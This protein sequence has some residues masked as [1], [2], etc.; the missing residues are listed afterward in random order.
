MSGSDKGF[1]DSN[2]Y[3]SI[4]G[5]WK[6]YRKHRIGLIGLF[7]M[8]LFFGMAIFAPALATH[9]PTPLVKVAP[10][11][12][13]PSWFSMFDP[14]GVV[15]GDYLDDPFIEEE[16]FMAVN[17]T[18][19]EFS[20][21]HQPIDDLNNHSYVN[22]T[23]THTAGTQLDFA[24][25]DPDEIMPDYNDFVYF[26]QIVTWPWNNKPS[27]VNMS[28]SYATELTG[29]FANT[30]LSGILMF[31][32]YVWI[33]DS[34]GQWTRL[35]ESRDLL[36]EDVVKEKPV[37]LNYFSINDIFDGMISLNGTSQEDPSDDITI[38]VGLA[39]RFT[40]E[41]HAGIFPWQEFNGSVEVKVTQLKMVAYGEYFGI[42]G[43]TN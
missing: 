19:D 2:W 21:L 12:L 26:D 23:W 20:Y 10:E 37:S 9:D 30:S 28:V 13:A 27:D 1:K 17:G 15:T 22:L 4:T 5:F 14:S 38:R 33:V 8:A 35:Y 40:F 16:P 41:S 42:L 7:I 43:T 3:V 6:E 25:K 32:I 24:G 18:S 34:G 36:Y 39:P 29:D 11:Y 31:R